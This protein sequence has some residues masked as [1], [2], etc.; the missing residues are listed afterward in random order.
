MSRPTLPAF[1]GLP[2]L[3]P[4]GREDTAKSAA[5]LRAVRPKGDAEGVLSALPCTALTEAEAATPSGP[6]IIGCLEIKAPYGRTPTATSV[7]LCGRDRSAVGHGKVLT[8]IDDHAAHRNEC[9]LR[10]T[11]E[12]RN[13]A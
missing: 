10:T 9:P 5:P 13:A 12:G 7:C 2:P 3:A 8:L 4:T 1:P 11:Q 6:Q